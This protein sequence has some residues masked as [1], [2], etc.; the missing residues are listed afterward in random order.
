[1]IR[2]L[3][4]NQQNIFDLFL[5]RQKERTIFKNI[6]GPFALAKQFG[7]HAGVTFG[8]ALHQQNGF[9]LVSILGTFSDYLSLR[10]I[11][12][13]LNRLLDNVDVSFINMEMGTSEFTAVNYPRMIKWMNR[14]AEIAQKRNVALVVKVH[15]STNQTHTHYGNFNFLPQ[16]ANPEVGILPHT[17]YMYG[18]NDDSAPMYG[19]KNFKHILDFML[20]E[21][22]KRRTWF[23]P[24]TS[25]FIAL[26]IDAP[27]L[28]TDYLLTRAED[29][30]ILYDN[31]IE[32]QLNFTTGQEVG[33]W[34][35]DWTYTLLNNKDY[36][37]DPMIGLKLLGEDQDS[38]QQIL[39][40]QNEYFKKRGLISIISFQNFGD[41]LFP[42]THQTLKRNPLKF[43]YRNKELLKEE[44][45]LLEEAMAA[46]PQD[47][48]IKNRQLR[49]MIEVTF[50][51]IEHAL[52]TRQAFLEKQSMNKYLEEAVAVRMEAQKRIDEIFAT[53]LYPEAK[54][55]EKHKNPTAYPYGYAYPVKNLHYWKREEEVIRRKKFSPFFMNITDFLD[56]VF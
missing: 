42:G 3:A 19:N 52:K 6:R 7:I 41:E 26:D 9:K 37:F 39:D 43:L 31:G 12:K 28:L 15:V 54:I 10:Q 16:Y 29:T 49:N 47:I 38:W 2:W 8:A 46:V 1:M 30:R 40:F 32:G 13:K 23:Y 22:D 36:E 21:K 5:L 35:F 25:Y 45:S 44:I 55:F 14:A 27:L 51:R 56:I 34:L 24:E 53:Q 18:L 17:V 4:R 20:Q 11:N 50:L 48:R 33:Y